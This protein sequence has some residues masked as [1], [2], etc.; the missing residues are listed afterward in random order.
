MH[1]M[2]SIILRVLLKCASRHGHV[3]APII[4]YN[5]LL[6]CRL[7]VSITGNSFRLIDPNDCVCFTVARH[8]LLHETF[9]SKL[10][11]L[12]HF[13]VVSD[14]LSMCQYSSR[15]ECVTNNCIY[16]RDG[17]YASC[18]DCRKYVVCTSGT[19]QLQ[20]CPTKQNWGFDLTNKQCRYKSPDCYDCSGMLNTVPLL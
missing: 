5:K 4:L 15:T 14:S 6:P 1:D 7:L 12:L 9:R 17:A 13:P 2:L 11:I 10:I 8:Y 16:M 18:D 3:A 19:S 20:S